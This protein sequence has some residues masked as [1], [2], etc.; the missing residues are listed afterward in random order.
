MSGKFDNRH[1]LFQGPDRH[2]IFDGVVRGIQGQPV[3]RHP[4]DGAIAVNGVG[5]E[6]P[7][8]AKTPI[9]H[10]IK[11][12]IGPFAPAERSIVLL[13]AGAGHHPRRD[14]D[15]GSPLKQG[16]KAGQVGDIFVA[17]RREKNVGVG[18]DFPKG[19][20]KSRSTPEPALAQQR[21]LVTFQHG[22]GSVARMAVDSDPS[23]VARGHPGPGQGW[24]N[25]LQ[26]GP[27]VADQQDQ[28]DVHC[29]RYQAM[30]RRRPS[31]MAIFAS[32]PIAWRAL[33]VSHLRR[34]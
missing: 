10:Q 11:R 31:G 27:L 26:A 1:A 7:G 12:V 20:Q 32:K 33:V 17:V 29:A 19:L 34:G 18:L 25:R 14:N 16:S 24:Q 6:R 3:R 15:I 2:L 28:R 5:D 22:D 21:N 4:G 23:I 9:G 13:V 8:A 30:V